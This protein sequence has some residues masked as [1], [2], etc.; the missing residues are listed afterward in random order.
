M[1]GS[2]RFDDADEL[3]YA[4]TLS[5][6]DDAGAVLWSRTPPT[7]APDDVWTAAE[8][9]GDQILGWTWSCHLVTFS[10]AGV[11]L[12]SVLTK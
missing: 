8:V 4:R 10:H 2:V 9:H 5:F 11:A 1:T 12:T 6:I 7:S 3:G